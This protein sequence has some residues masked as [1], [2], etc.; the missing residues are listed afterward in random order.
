MKK[1]MTIV[2]A[3]LFVAAS[4]GMAIA[5][6]D[7]SKGPAPNAGDGIPDGSG[8]CNCGDENCPPEDCFLI[9]PFGDGVPEDASQGP[10]PNAG[11]GIPDGPG[12]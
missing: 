4:F 5:G 9:G 12:W 2:G 1:M 7:Y 3:L 11:D 8:F 6:S 10:A